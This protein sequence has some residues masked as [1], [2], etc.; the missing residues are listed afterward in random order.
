MGNPYPVELAGELSP[1]QRY[2]LGS[3]LSCAS[4][5]TELQSRYSSAWFC[6]LELHRRMGE[7]L[8]WC[9]CPL[10]FS[11]GKDRALVSLAQTFSLC[12]F[13]RHSAANSLS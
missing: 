8:I 13:H 3:S 10:N 4:F 6:L 1:Q 2:M 5:L 11:E 9:K 12:N 7:K